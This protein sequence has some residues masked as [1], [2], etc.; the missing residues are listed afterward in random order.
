MAAME[1]LSASRLRKVVHMTGQ[2]AELR[3]LSEFRAGVVTLLR[4]LVPCESASYNEVRPGASAIVVAD[5]EIPPTSE[6]I[7]V[8]GRFSHENPL[9]D[10][11]MRTGDGQAL[12]FSD[13]ISQRALHR[14]A[15]YEHVY[16]ELGVEHQIAFV[17]PSAPG[18]VVGLA[19]NRERRDFTDAEAAMLNLLRRPL[20][21][22][23]ERLN[24]R[25]QLTSLLGAYEAESLSA[26]TTALALSKRE[27]Q[28][29]QGVSGGA[30]NA[31]LATSLGISKRTVEKHLQRIYMV[32]DVTSRTQAIARMQAAGVPAQARARAGSA[33]APG[34][35]RS[36]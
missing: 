16:R 15:L 30:S 20:R 18:E 22:C 10:H 31:E 21:A 1:S 26:H 5:P 19:L 36:Q 14:L 12:R 9:I 4:E 11:Y 23:Y 28:V 3:D 7:E 33:C 25:E 27:V 34:R 29:M 35:R 6:S 2:V 8:F 17:L 32:L 24:E 13:F